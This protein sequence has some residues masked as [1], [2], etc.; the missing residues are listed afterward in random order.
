MANSDP[1][2][3]RA[4]YAKEL[5]KSTP[6]NA[7]GNGTALYSNAGYILMGHVIE[8][9][10]VPVRIVRTATYRPGAW[11]LLAIYTRTP[12]TQHTADVG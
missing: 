10:S 8:I 6:A 11:A 5:L 2:G 12:G 3:Q 4:Q 7:V 9:V 1:R